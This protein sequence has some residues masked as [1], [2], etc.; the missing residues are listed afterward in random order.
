M[1]S[2]T[3]C[4]QSTQSMSEDKI[5]DALRQGPSAQRMEVLKSL[6]VSSEQATSYADLNASMK[7]EIKWLRPRTRL[8]GSTALM[9]FPCRDM[10]DSASLFLLRQVQGSWKVTDEQGHDCHYDSAVSM[11]LAPLQEASAD[12][13][14]VYHACDEHGTGM[15]SQKMHVYRIEGDKLVEQLS[16]Q[17]RYF[18]ESWPGA[19][20]EDW[21]ST[22]V[23]VS[24]TRQGVSA[25][26]ETRV[27]R[28]D[29]STKVSRRYF[30]WSNSDHAFRHTSFT[31]VKFNIPQ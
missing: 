26:E 13:I 27:D 2:V 25:L 19:G 21:R 15:V 20:H 24:S 8:A 9:F 12:D 6:G 31:Q 4:A 22:F 11:E 17:D 23:A 14:V 18:M 10:T 5:I 3:A 1:I 16:L 7:S 28:S 29:A 30:Y